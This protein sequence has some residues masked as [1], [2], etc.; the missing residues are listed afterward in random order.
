MC[1][2]FGKGLDQAWKDLRPDMAQAAE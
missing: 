1:D 2:A